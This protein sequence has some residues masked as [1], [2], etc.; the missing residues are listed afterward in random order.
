MSNYNGLLYIFDRQEKLLSVLNNEA[1]E[2]DIFF[3]DEFKKELNGEWSYKFSVDMSKTKDLMIEYNK[4]GFYDRR[5]NFQ[6][7][8]IHDIEDNISYEA[9][10]TVYCLHDF[11]SLNEDIV[12][13]GKI[14]GDARSALELVLKGS[15]YSVGEVSATEQQ[16]KNFSMLTKLDA[17]YSMIET[18]NLE[19][20]YRI[21]LN[22]TK[23]KIS[24]RYVD[25]VERLG[26]DTSLN[27]DFSLNIE[28]IKRKIN[29]NFFTVLYGRGK[30]LEDG[31]YSNFSES[32][33]VS[34]KNPTN[35]PKGQIWVSDEKAIAKYGIRKGIYSNEN[36]SRSDTLLRRTWEKLQ[37]INKPKINY[38]ASVYELSSII[39]HEN[40]KV[41]LGDKFKIV[42]NIYN[43][44]E[45]VRIIAEY[46]S[47][48]DEL[49][50][51]V[52]LGDP[53]TCFTDDMNGD[54]SDIEEDDNLE[55]G[56]GGEGGEDGSGEEV[57]GEDTLPDVP[58]VTAEGHFSTVTITW[59]F[60]NKSYY[61]YEVYASNVKGFAPAENNK[62]FEGK[63]SAFLHEV[64][65]SEIW[66]YKVRARNG[67]G[68]CT[69]FSQEVSA[70]TLKIA[71]GTKYFES[72]A[73]KDALIGDLNLDRGWVGELKGYYIDAKNLSVTDGNGKRT[74][75]IDSFGNVNLDVTSLKISSQDVQTGINDNKTNISN[76]ASRVSTAESKIT[77]SAIV[78]TVTSSTTWKTQTNNITTA[79]NTANTANA[80][81][82]TNK[83]NI[84]NL[85]SRVSTAEQKITA[86]AIVS[87]VTS[88]STYKND[89]TGKVSTN[90]VVSSIN[91]TAESVKI[92]ANKIQLE[93]AVTV[94][95]K[96]GDSI[97]I[98][99]GDY[100][101]RSDSTVKGFLGLRDLDDNYTVP[102]LALGQDGLLRS[103]NNY[104]VIQAYPKN[105]NPQN[106]GYPY[107]DIAYRLQKYKTSENVGD[108][109]NIKMYGDGVTR[110]SPVK[111][112]EITT[113]FKNGS[114]NGEGE[115]LIAEFGS[116]SSG[117]YDKYMDIPAIRN[118]QT[119]NGLILAHRNAN[120][121]SCF[122]RVNCDSNGD[123]FFR[124]LTSDGNI[125]L[126]SG[127]YQWKSVHSKTTYSSAGVIANDVEVI[128]VNNNDILDNINFISTLSD[129]EELIIDVTNIKN[130]NYVDSYENN[131]YLNNN[132]IIKLLLKE[133]K[134]LKEELNKLKG[135]A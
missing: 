131:V 82:N 36:I 100:E 24:K 42:D 89:L 33:W 18:Y 60:E 38:E 51:K 125:S 103:S 19:A 84:S 47:I 120:D 4:V 6:L 134:Q 63:A 112:L 124:P 94:A 78:N 54:S 59:T 119:T 5:G 27:F 32:E 8:V 75:D 135:G 35:K 115:S 45:E 88:S 99:N 61:T 68:N 69:E 16:V 114:Y 71:D 64:E 39:G 11:Q 46:E 50:K 102:R 2:G 7:F 49:G 109:S 14:I 30:Q 123:R 108:V 90:K 57:E 55:D 83:T 98:N 121:Q 116:S 126:G 72:M 1:S 43:I 95:N 107:V 13:E 92:K 106:Y 9:T 79:Q 56:E 41:N 53:L 52:E 67:Y 20:Y 130:T 3:D 48:L 97:K 129:E 91:Q 40:L 10:R 113:N 122:V 101:I 87:T 93:G 25:L 128:P 23:T 104:F 74:L 31:S 117:Y 80:T 77:A 22:E 132:E 118:T 17:I 58:I 70:E 96:N 127:N 28:S 110:L 111:T 86:D 85:T 37:K 133:V 66:Y 81:A 62:I 29:N 73:I 105:N 21:E 44:N 26:R 12:E 65:P 34:P 76:L 15:N